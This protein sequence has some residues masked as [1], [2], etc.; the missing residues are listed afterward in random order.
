MRIATSQFYI[1]S[2][3]DM[4]DVQ[5]RLQT[6]QIQASSGKRIN[7]PSDDPIGAAKSLVL[8]S[9]EFAYGQYLRNINS[10]DNRLQQEEAAY[11]ELEQLMSRVK[12]LALQAAN[13]GISNKQTRIGA[14]AE[15][16]EIEA[17]MLR[18]AN[19]KD[20]NG[21]YIFA[22]L[23]V[24]ALPYE[25]PG[26]SNKRATTDANGMGRIR[27]HGDDLQRY[28]DIDPTRRLP[29]TDPGSD[30][31]GESF[32]KSIFG[33][34]D[35]LIKAFESENTMTGGLG[36][37]SSLELNRKINQLI[38]NLDEQSKQV[39][40]THASVGARLQALNQ[41]QRLNT[42]LQTQYVSIRSN[43]ES[44][45]FAKAATNLTLEATAL[46]ASQLAFVQVRGLSLFNYLSPGR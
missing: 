43:I 19:L 15:A 27:Y 38:A 9:Q 32:N 41:E 30:A 3:D 11:K 13:T 26:D 45:D 8:Q 24:F 46:Q 33:T 12:V 7:K 25:Q 2:A 39:V 23:E 29:Y 16:R 4:M 5:E 34:M 18:L 42:T 21:E 6:A 22:G 35:G 1:Q 10:A 14:A 31:F 37:D 40:A 20:A 28:M 36:V 17:E 44:V